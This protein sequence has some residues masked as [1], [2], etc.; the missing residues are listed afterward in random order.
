MQNAADEVPLYIQ[1]EAPIA[2]AIARINF[3]NLTALNPDYVVVSNRLLNTPFGTYNEPVKAYNAYRA[4]QAG[5]AYDTLTVFMEQLF[6]QFNYGEKSPLALFRFS[7]YLVENTKAEYVFLIGK[8]LRWNFDP[9]RRARNQ[10]N[11]YDEF[12]P[13][14]G[15]P[16]A[17]NL[18]GYNIL[19][20]N[21][22]AL[23]F[24]RL[25][26]HNS[27]IV[28][29][30][31]EKITEMEAQPIDNLRRKAFL[32][33][34]GGLSESEINTFKGFID[35][36]STFAESPYIGGAAEELT[37]QS[38]Q[39]VE[40]LNVSEQVNKGV[41]MITF[42]GHSGT[43][44]SDIDIGFVSTTD[45]GYQNKGKYPLIFINGCNAGAIYEDTTDALTFGENWVNTADLGAV[46]VM[47]HTALGIPSELKR[48]SDI[49]YAKAFADSALIDEPI[50][51]IHLETSKAYLDIFSA[52]P[53]E[54]VLS[55]AQ[56]FNLM[57][58]PAYKLFPTNKPDFEVTDAD[59]DLVSLNG[60]PVDALTTDFAFDLIIRNYGITTADS[61][62]IFVNRRLADNTLIPLDTQYF[63]SPYNKD[64][65]RVFIENSNIGQFGE[66]TFE[67]VLDPLDSIS[68]INELNNTA[69]F[70]YFFSLGTTL[71]LYP[72]PFS[73]TNT[74]DIKLVAQSIDL[75]SEE[76]AYLFELDSVPTF[77]SPFLK[78][79]TITAK[80]IARWNTQLSGQNGKAFF[81]RTKFAQ[82]GD[83]EIDQWSKSSFI[84]NAEA[85]KGWAQNRLNQFENNEISGLTLG[86]N[87]WK[88][89]E[90]TIELAVKSPA[91]IGA[92]RMSIR[93]N[94]EEYSPYG[95]A[96]DECT[97]NSLYLVAFDQFT[98]TPYRILNNGGFDRLDPFTCGRSP[99]VI[100]KIPNAKLNDPTTYFQKYYDELSVGDYVLLTSFDSVAWNILRANNRNE[101]LDLGASAAV[102]D[103]IQNGNPYIL[104]GQKGAGEGT[105][106]ESFSLE[107]PE[108]DP[109]NQLLVS[110]D[111][112]IDIRFNTGSVTSTTVGPAR[113]WQELN[114]TFTDLESTDQ[115]R[116]DVFGIDSLNNQTLLLSDVT[117]PATISNINAAIYPQLRLRTIL[118]D[119]INFT[120]ARLTQWQV[121]YEELPDAVLLLNQEVPDGTVAVAEGI[122]YPLKYTAVNVTP[123]NFTDSITATLNLFNQSS[124]IAESKSVKIAALTAESSADFSVSIN[125][126]GKVGLNNVGMVLNSGRNTEF[127]TINNQINLNKLLDIKR[128]SLPPFIDVTF[129]GINILDNDIVSPSPVILLSLKDENT[130]LARTDTAGITLSLQPL[131][132]GCV[133]QPI[134]FSNSR[135]SYEPATAE[136]P[137]TITYR[138]ETFE[139]GRYTLRA[140]ATDASG[141]SAGEEP[142]R[143]TFEVVNASTITNFYPYPNPFSTQTR[144]VFTLTGTEIP[145]EIKIQILTISGRVVREILQDEIGMIHIGN[146]ITEYAWDGRDEYGDRLANGVYLYRVLVRNNGSFMEQRA[147]SAD[148]AFK[149]GYGKLY[150]LR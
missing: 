12:V 102:F 42:F 16:G 131:C 135:V 78:R 132:E 145:N 136:K 47:A 148:K 33:L 57:G 71:N 137:F 147:T 86:N 106:I 52:N 3:R 88:F 110:L 90:K 24:G 119:T 72:Y 122:D 117:L 149:K 27:E 68:E 139:D 87:S 20:A 93:I 79:E 105:G 58:D 37:K 80:V 85:N 92:D 48:Y 60:L 45:L 84:F 19:E 5:G 15:Y 133:S 14:A 100:N 56:Q 39:V 21:R 91:E 111:Q 112:S 67:F 6:D 1:N 74:N 36:F 66:S 18:Y 50:G 9:Y 118:T 140:N 94:N 46:H 96:V 146:N 40:D 81:W 75:L 59:I 25:N 134:Y 129:D 31:L 29:N 138:P 34:S 69:T 121:E 141:N 7:R 97:P 35:D 98:G 23:S 104:F 101:V 144:F 17:D 126:R 107:Q 10:P 73:L 114:A 28:V 82:I 109:I 62:A 142:Y 116:I 13:S 65:L 26:A 51:K 64:T 76:R 55:Q 130:S 89:L 108:D 41:N 128:D 54:L 49:F 103:A 30:Y 113:S 53:S 70:D 22:P 115:V 95:F 127:R 124:R 8:G 4:S 143:I 44:S 61:L 38:T 11:L 125:T 99:Q 63:A 77:D 123:N 32:H 120:A 43:A 2:P 83:G 150:I